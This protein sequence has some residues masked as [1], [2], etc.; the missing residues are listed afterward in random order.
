MLQELL[1][2]GEQTGREN[3]NKGVLKV[4]LAFFDHINN[5]LLGFHLKLLKKSD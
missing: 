5:S 4:S 2:L 3:P 1:V